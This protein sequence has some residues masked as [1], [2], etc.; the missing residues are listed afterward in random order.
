MNDQPRISDERLFI[1]YAEG[2]GSAFRLLMV[3]HAPG[4]LRFCHGYLHE[5]ADAEDAVQETFV[6]AIR[7]ATTYRATHKFS[8]WLYT[9]AK[10]HCLDV[11]KVKSRRSLLREERRQR[12]A[13][14]TMGEPIDEVGQ[15]GPS[16]ALQ[17][18][19]ER[20]VVQAETGTD[21]VRIRRRVLTRVVLGVAAGVAIFGSLLPSA[22]QMLT[23]ASS[24]SW[25]GAALGLAASG[26]ILLI[27]S[28]L[29]FISRR[30]LEES[31]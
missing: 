20:S 29:L 16:L 23:W 11:L 27:S 5:E 10:N 7:S 21:P 8:T 4:V 15:V 2:D 31:S 30:R 13:E 19:L 25:Q 3:K 6:K 24:L 28:P 22:E 17:K 26:L 12:I 9:I 1:R 18:R 14:A